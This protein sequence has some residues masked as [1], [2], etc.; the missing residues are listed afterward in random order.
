M[1]FTVKLINL[2][3]K[4]SGLKKKYDLPEEQFLEEARKMNKSRGFFMPKNKRT[5][6]REHVVMGHQVL[7]VQKAEERSERAILCFLGWR[8]GD[9]PGQGR[10]GRIS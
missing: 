5:V 2:A 7:L 3:T 1:S 4:M 8:Y 6:Y 9:R 10:C